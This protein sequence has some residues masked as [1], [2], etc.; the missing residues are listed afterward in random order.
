MA[1]Q[2]CVF[3]MRVCRAEPNPQTQTTKIK[4]SETHTKQRNTLTHIRRKA[5]DKAWWDTVT[6]VFT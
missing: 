5:A 1:V 3:C 4:Q 6:E 2:T